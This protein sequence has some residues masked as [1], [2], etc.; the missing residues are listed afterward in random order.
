M[1][2]FGAAALAA[3]DYP[4]KV[5][6]QQD[7]RQNRVVAI[8]SGRA[9]IYVTLSFTRAENVDSDHPWPIRQVIPAGKTVEMARVYAGDPAR[10]YRFSYSYT[11]L[12]G[13]PAA[14]P[15]PNATYR[16][17]FEDGKSLSIAQAPGGPVFTHNTPDS[18]NAVDIAM[19]L[20]TTIVA[21]RAGY[22]IENV[23]PFDS[24]R[25]EPYFLDKSNFVRIMH[26]DGT[27]ADYAHLQKYSANIYPGMR[28]SA[29][30]PI[31]LSG[32]SGYSSGPH[33][34]FVVQRNDGGKVVSV[35]FRFWNRA[36]GAF[37]PVYQGE[38]VADY[39]GTLAPA[40]PTGTAAGADAP[41]PH[42][43]RSVKECMGG[44]NVINEAVLRCTRGY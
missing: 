23:R 44:A 2:A 11:W 30:T 10:A 3:S 27:W 29:G 22:V 37:V 41:A 24:G 9:P 4:F 15:D 18:S 40:L 43:P 13:D 35:P 21:A 26:D 36:D 19:P 1:L 6:A 17:P 14:R 33:L 31:G 5:D 25:L 20:G 42:K 32:S 39:A 7:G 38:L 34:H 12:F 8:N 28:I 16:L